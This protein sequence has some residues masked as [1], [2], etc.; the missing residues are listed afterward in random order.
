MSAAAR[1]R[2][3]S[4]SL[5]SSFHCGAARMMSLAR[6]SWMS[7]A[8]VFGDGEVLEAAS[9]SAL[10]KKSP[11]QASWMA[12]WA[13]ASEMMAGCWNSMPKPR[14]IRGCRRP[15]GQKSVTWGNY[16]ESIGTGGWSIPANMRTSK[17]S[18][19]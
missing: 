17:S 19:L 3:P 1:L 5:L 18:D 15:S 10:S 2:I 6:A 7:C 12:A 13:R 8:S 4:R 11:I 14:W 9:F 16:G